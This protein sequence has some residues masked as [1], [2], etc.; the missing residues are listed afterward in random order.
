MGDDGVLGEAL[1]CARDRRFLLLLE[2]EFNVFLSRLPASDLQPEEGG[3]GGG[4]KGN[5]ATSQNHKQKY[6]GEAEKEKQEQEQ[7]KE[8]EKSEREV[9]LP[10][11][12]SY[13]RLLAHKTAARFGLVSRSVGERPNRQTVISCGAKP[14]KCDIIIIYNFLY[15][16]LYTSFQL[17][18]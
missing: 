11:L 17:L 6:E 5:E 9:V 14:A 13:H 10:V 2:D 15:Y 12:S 8:K 7:E 18:G 1:R 16:M 3:G 4:E